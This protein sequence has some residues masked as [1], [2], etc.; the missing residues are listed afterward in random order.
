MHS[1]SI[2]LTIILIRLIIQVMSYE[3]KSIHLL[4]AHSLYKLSAG[5][6]VSCLS[7]SSV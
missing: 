3:H 5:P 6:A 4:Y 7:S 1:N 2:I